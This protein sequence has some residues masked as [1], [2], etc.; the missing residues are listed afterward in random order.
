MNGKSISRRKNCPQL[1]KEYERDLKRRELNGEIKECTRKT[2]LND[3][4]RVLE[5]LLV[6]S[7]REEIRKVM[8][9]QQYKGYYAN[10]INDLK[11][12]IARRTL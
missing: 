11:A 2:Y 1:L 5:S 12:I 10:I 8:V 4:N 3:A 6:T 9:S 7:P